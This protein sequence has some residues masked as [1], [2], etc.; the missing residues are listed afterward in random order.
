[1]LLCAP[2]L[3]GCSGDGTSSR[4]EQDS[5]SGDVVMPSLTRESDG[6]STAVGTLAFRR[7]LGEVFVL[8]DI[9]PGEKPSTEARVIAVLVESKGQ[10][11]AEDLAPLVGAYCA[12][13]GSLVE[14]ETSSTAHAP[15]LAIESYRILKM[16]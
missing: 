6:R 11:G 1:M 3:S 16:P 14:T 4:T 13:S 12:F 15:R 7:D 10:T 9:T 2:F 5:T 8:V